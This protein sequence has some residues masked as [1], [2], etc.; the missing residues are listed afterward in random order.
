MIDTAIC[1]AR[2]IYEMTPEVR[3]TV[4]GDGG[5]C[6]ERRRIA[7]LA[8]VFDKAYETFTDKDWLDPWDM[9]MVPYLLHCVRYSEDVT[10]AMVLDALAAW[11]ALAQIEADKRRKL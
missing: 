8:E 11:V 2:E 6:S 10:E 5:Y 1:V 3:A 4:L 9:D 7:A